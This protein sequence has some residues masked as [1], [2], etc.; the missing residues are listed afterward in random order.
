[1]SGALLLALVAALVGYRLGLGAQ[2]RRA[3]AR[4]WR[5]LQGGHHYVELHRAEVQA[6]GRPIQEGDWVVVY[7]EV[8]EENQPWGQCYAREVY[9]FQAK[10]VQRRP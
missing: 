7:R 4:Y 8:D 10:F 5:H 9:E 3:R 1:M 2:Q 6:S